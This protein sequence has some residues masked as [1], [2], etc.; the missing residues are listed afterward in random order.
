MRPGLDQRQHAE[1][2]ERPAPAVG[3]RPPEGAG[4]L[5]RVSD[6]QRGP[7]ERQQP[8]AAEEGPGRVR[9]GDRAGHR[10]EQDPE[11]PRAGPSAGADDGRV[12]G[13]PPP[14]ALARPA[15]AP[16]FNHA[17]QRMSDRLG[18]P[19]SQRYD[20]RHYQP[21]RQQPAPPL[22]RAGGRDGRLDRLIG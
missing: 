16:S 5:R 13:E 4:V 22:A 17:G 9:R 7:V 2:R 6:L 10:V 19:E 1:L 12:V 20:Q 14:A 3:R 18:C 11:Q 15:I 21:G 8:Q